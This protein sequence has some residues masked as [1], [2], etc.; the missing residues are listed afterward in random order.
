MDG[1]LDDYCRVAEGVSHFLYLTHSAS[2]ERSISLLAISVSHLEKQPRLQ[3]DLPLGLADEV[4]RPGTKKGAARWSADRA[5]DKIRD[6]FGW[7][8]IG[9]GSVILG[10]RKSVPDAFRS[11]AEKEL[12]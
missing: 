10:D 3:L 9:Y 5:M 11:L 2:Q 8:A 4:H 7:D 12:P 1:A 6:R